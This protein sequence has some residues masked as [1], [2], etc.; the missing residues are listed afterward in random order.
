MKLTEKGYVN[1]IGIICHGVID[2]VLLLAYLLELVKGSRTPGYFAVIAVMLVLPIVAEVVCYC[3][4]KESMVIHH[5]MGVCYSTLYLF[6]IFTTN[7]QNTFVYAI[8]MYIVITLFSDVL[9]CIAISAGGF[10]GNLVF[11]IYHAKTVGY[12]AE[13]LPDVEI[14]L[15]CM[16]LT[17]I[18]MVVTCMATKKVN[19][20]KLSTINA[21][22]DKTAEILQ[23]VLTTAETMVQG[24]GEAS[25][26]MAALGESVSHIHDS[27]EEVST[28]STETA[29]SVQTQMQ[30]TEQIQNH[31]IKVKETAENI[32][33]NMNLATK[34]V[35]SGKEN[36]DALTRQVE[37]SK[38]ANERVQDR[39][40][41]LE[42]YTRQMNDITEAI[43]SIAGKTGMLAL[44]ASIEAARAGEAG[45]GF[46][47]VADQITG[48]ANQTKEATVNIGALIDNIN[49]ELA[50]VFS[51]VEVVTEGNQANEASAKAVSVSFEKIMEDTQNIGKQTED[52]KE[53][54]M[55]LESANADIVENIQTIS[56]I[57]EE[58]SAHSSETYDACEVNGRLVEAVTGIVGGL[59]EGAEKLK[60]TY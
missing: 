22:K 25:E 28:G 30:R 12:T 4:N 34:E 45:R 35:E 17:G 37:K 41:E 18:F 23:E 9:Y 36:M 31:I 46:A 58:V 2:M 56:A 29:E 39:M 53:T 21:Q 3:K 57:T 48:L 27:M 44:N 59:K 24:I 40:Q 10:L 5:I 49:Q 13:E 43:T 15:A 11:V 55:Q 33:R 42:N 19:N 52:M 32:D 51:A 6:A 38:E 54:V 47:V 16:L 14:R 7:S 26:K 8:P 1:K 50:A 60:K 20:S